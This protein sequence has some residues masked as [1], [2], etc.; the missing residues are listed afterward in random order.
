MP[1][2]IDVV[3]TGENATVDD[4]VELSNEIVENVV[5]SYVNFKCVSPADLI[6]LQKKDVSLRPFYDLV[7]DAR[8]SVKIPCFVLQNHVLVRKVRKNVLLM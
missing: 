1:E 6:R 4:K 3:D 5:N 8:D 2:G 7:V